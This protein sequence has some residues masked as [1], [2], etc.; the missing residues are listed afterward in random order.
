V[1]RT[2]VQCASLELKLS[3][4]KTTRFYGEEPTARPAHPSGGQAT[5]GAIDGSAIEP[6]GGEAADR[7]TPSHPKPVDPGQAP[8]FLVP[9]GGPGGSR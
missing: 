9:Q 5:E 2:E 3:E 6:A 7:V 8:S 4:Q 1:F